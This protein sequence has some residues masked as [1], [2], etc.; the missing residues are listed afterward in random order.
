METEEIS[1]SAGMGRA[2]E[3]N[4]QKIDRQSRRIQWRR[5]MVRPADNSES[6]LLF[7]DIRRDSE[8]SLGNTVCL[9]APK[10]GLANE[11]A[12]RK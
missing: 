7:P 9:I 6:A 11:I 10:R 2:R 8:T 1:P 4:G 5:D 3:D 12:V